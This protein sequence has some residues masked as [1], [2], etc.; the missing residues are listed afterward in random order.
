MCIRDRF[1]GEKVNF[2]LFDL[3]MKTDFDKAEVLYDVHVYS[4]YTLIGLITLHILA[5]LLHTFILKDDVI[6]RIT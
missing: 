6:K 3:K 2:F 1:N 5:A 4:N